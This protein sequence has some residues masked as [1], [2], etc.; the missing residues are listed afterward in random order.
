MEPEGLFYL[1]WQRIPILGI[2]FIQQLFIGLVGFF[3]GFVFGS[4]CILRKSIIIVDVVCD[5][6][7]IIALF[8]ISQ[9]CYRF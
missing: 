5:G 3:Q 2:L 4:V 9:R 7:I 6:H 1:L 8:I